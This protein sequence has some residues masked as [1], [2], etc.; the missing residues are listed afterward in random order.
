MKK[1]IATGLL[2]TLCSEVS[3]A[4][5]IDDSKIDANLRNFYFDRDYKSDPYPYPAARD[6]AQGLIIKAQSGYSEGKIGFGLD[7][8]AMA[9]VNLYAN[10]EDYARSGLLRVSNDNSRDD[11]YAKFGLTGKV[12]Y[13]NNELFIGDLMPL[14]PTVFSSQARLLPQTYRGIKLQT[15]EIPKFQLEAYYLDQTRFRDSSDYEDV[16][17]DNLNRRYQGAAQTDYFYTL[18]GSYQLNPSYRLRAYHAELKDIYQQQ[19]FGFNGKH[20]LDHNLELRS[21]LRFFNSYDTG[22]AKVGEIDNRH[23][24]G[25]VGLNRNNHTFSLGYMQS[26]GD[27]AIPF[28]S[29]QESPVMLD[30][31]SSDYSNKDEKV[32]YARYDLSFNGKTL[33][34]VPLDGL[35]FMTR[36]AK[37]VDVDLN[38]DNQD[39]EEESIEAEIGYQV[40]EGK[41]KGLGLR[42]RYSH[43][44]NDFPTNMTF[45][46]ANELRLNVDYTFRFK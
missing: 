27:S 17:I 30:L 22:D 18:G 43:Y 33:A 40:P 8:N 41:L 12:K 36:Y 10:A 32:Y 2:A 19:F 29:G 38:I 46:S 37:G 15:N 24:S 39:F 6:W 5:F 23:I 35:R 34:E 21:E 11:F 45:H 26:F 1:M 16:G 31:M 7:V 42:A 44:R 4:A 14:I 3:Y 28:L 9:A 25:L 20:K 13:R